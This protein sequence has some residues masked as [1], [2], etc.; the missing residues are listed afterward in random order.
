MTLSEPQ[1][2]AVQKSMIKGQEF[3]FSA[4]DCLL[5]DVGDVTLEE[6]RRRGSVQGAKDE[7]VCKEGSD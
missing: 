2:P 5:M 7:A 6:V 4:W 1:P 3:N